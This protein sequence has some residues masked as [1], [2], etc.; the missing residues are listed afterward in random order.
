MALREYCCERC[1]ETQYV[2]EGEENR[3]KQGNCGKMTRW[4][5]N[6]VKMPPKVMIVHTTDTW[7]SE[8]HLDSY[9]TTYELDRQLNIEA[10]YHRELKI[11]NEARKNL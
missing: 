10:E 7:M 2:F 6:F 4:C 1:G 8:P 5:H 9:E 11:L 3:L